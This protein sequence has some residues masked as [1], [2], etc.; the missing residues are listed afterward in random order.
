MLFHRLRRWNNI[1]PTLAGCRQVTTAWRSNQNLL[2]LVRPGH[3]H[4]SIVLVFYHS[5]PQSVSTR[6]PSKHQIM[7]PIF[8]YCWASLADGGLAFNP[9]LDTCLVSVVN[10]HPALIPQRPNVNLIQ[11]RNPCTYIFWHTSILYT[12][13]IFSSKYVIMC[14]C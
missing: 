12:D 14:Y 6:H 3:E 5:P 1:K 4:C 8:D 7:N 2:W 11:Y 13:V 10:I 9:R